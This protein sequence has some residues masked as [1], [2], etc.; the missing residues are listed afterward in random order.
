MAIGKNRLLED[1]A[2][3]DAARGNL[4][5]DVTFLKQEVKDKGVG[6]RLLDM[7]TDNAQTIA[8]GARDLAEDNR[9]KMAGGAALA[10]A[11]IAAW[12]F[13]KPIMAAIDELIADMQVET[14]NLLGEPDES[15]GVIVKET[16]E[17]GT[18]E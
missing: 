14:A 16:I 13:R 15:E 18:P 3:R 1:R 11:G 6:A 8:A 17:D 9:G 2:L 7:S 12:I 10:I 5:H 4:T